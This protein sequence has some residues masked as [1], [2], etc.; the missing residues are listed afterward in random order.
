MHF[1]EFFDA[2]LLLHRGQP[3]QAMHR[4]R[5]PPEQF[6]NWYNGLWRPWYAALWAE[7]AVLAGHPDAAERIQRARPLTVDNPIAAAIVRRATCLHAG[8]P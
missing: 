1:G 4:L 7:A 6:R 8:R 2:W 5:T 3:D